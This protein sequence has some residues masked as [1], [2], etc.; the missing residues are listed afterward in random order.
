M[1]KKRGPAIPLETLQVGDFTEQEAIAAVLQDNPTLGRVSKLRSDGIRV[2]F[3]KYQHKGCQVRFGV[4]PY[5]TPQNEEENAYT[6]I[7]GPIDTPHKNHPTTRSKIGLPVSLPSHHPPSLVCSSILPL[8]H[9]SKRLKHMTSTTHPCPTSI[10][11]PPTTQHPQ[12]GD[13]ALLSFWLSQ[14]ASLKPKALQCMALR[15]VTWQYKG[16]M[17]VKKD[18]RQKIARWLQGWT[19]RMYVKVLPD[20]RV[21][22]NKWLEVHTHTHTR[23]HQISPFIIP[24]SSTTHR[25]TNPW[26][27]L[28]MRT[29]T[30]QS[31]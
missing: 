5:R 7:V 22:L 28:L 23:A 3:C 14:D 10:P 24:M 9:Q 15:E 19:K 20:D 13:K 16:D 4:G 26:T 21:S 30:S 18:L 31:L 29:C 11:H 8:V 2:L 12:D 25:I 17:N 6:E 1:R 27:R